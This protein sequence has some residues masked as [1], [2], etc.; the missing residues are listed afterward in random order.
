MIWE[1]GRDGRI[2][3]FAGDNLSCDV[4]TASWKSFLGLK[5]SL[6]DTLGGGLGGLTN[7]RRGFQDQVPASGDGPA[8]VGRLRQSLH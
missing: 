5:I 1:Y 7:K 3:V 8:F 4:L 6:L 2:A